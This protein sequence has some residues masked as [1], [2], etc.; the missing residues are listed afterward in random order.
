[1]LRTSLC[2]LLG[3]EPPIAAP[4]RA[5]CSI[6]LGREWDWTTWFPSPHL[7]SAIPM[8][9]SLSLPPTLRQSPILHYTARLP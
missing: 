1:M 4:T 3:I 6:T 5:L 7:R 9:M 8:E 2:D